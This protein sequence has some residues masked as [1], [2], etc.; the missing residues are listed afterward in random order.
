MQA[1]AYE[2]TIKQLLEKL[3]AG[4]TKCSKLEQVCLYH[5]IVSCHW[6]FPF[7]VS[8]DLP[9]HLSNLTNTFLPVWLFICSYP[10]VQ[11]DPMPMQ[12]DT[13]QPSE[14]LESGNLA[15]GQEASAQG[16]KGSKRN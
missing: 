11:R 12:C 6:T 9:A 8:H 5:C 15:A 3:Q 1:A 14:I 10:H 13:Q 4:E 7:V 16:I 2:A